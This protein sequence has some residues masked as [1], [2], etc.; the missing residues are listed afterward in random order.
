[1]LDAHVSQIRAGAEY[2]GWQFRIIDQSATHV[3]YETR[4]SRALRWRRMAASIG[5]DDRVRVG[6]GSDVGAV[7][8]WRRLPKS[9]RKALMSGKRAPETSEEASVALGFARF[10][11]SAAGLLSSLTALLVFVVTA[12]IVLL[13]L[14]DGLDAFDYTIIAAVVGA[15]GFRH[16]H[17]YRRLRA[18]AS[19]A[20]HPTD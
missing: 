9:T 5:T 18:T 20:L 2:S 8:A 4:P 10:A 6:G 16:F 12:V 11:L 19:R 3:V 1:M 7:R 14:G 13:A 15:G 17:L